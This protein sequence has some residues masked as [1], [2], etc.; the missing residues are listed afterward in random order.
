MKDD[1]ELLR[2]YAHDRSEPAF[3]ELVRRHVNFVYSAA[4]RQ[5]NG[6]AHLAGD[7]TQIVFTDL[8]RKAKSLAGHQVLAGWLFTSTRFAASRL[9]RTEQRRRIREQEAEVMHENEPLETDSAAWERISPVLDEALGQLN[10]VDRDAVLLRYFEGR[11]FSEI[12]R[13]LRLS[14][15]A[16]RM[17]VERALEKLRDQLASRGL[18]STTATLGA[19]LA[20]YGVVGAPTSLGA[21]VTG[22]ALA[23]GGAAAT[24]VFTFMS[25]SKLPAAT[26]AALTLIGGAGY[27]LQA[28]TQAQL[29]EELARLHAAQRSPEAGANTVDKADGALAAELA[30]LRRDDAEFARLAAEAEAL[31]AR[32]GAEKREP[33]SPASIPAVSGPILELREL[34]IRP[35]P[36]IQARPVYPPAMR[37]AGLGGEVVVDFVVDQDGTVRN[38]NVRKSKIVAN[39]TEIRR[40]DLLTRAEPSKIPSTDSSALHAASGQFSLNGVTVSEAMFVAVETSALT[41]VR[42]WEF[43]AGQKSGAKV[44]TRMAIPIVFSPK[45]LPAV[46][47]ATL[48]KLSDEM[49]WF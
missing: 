26:A 8:A 42:Q 36:L 25:M 2:L 44:N 46:T 31:R 6:D 29:R 41:A 17:R 22:A 11:G 38:A 47:P 24:T 10:T 39:E 12:G 43:S 30:D 19:A 49:R 32:F 16:A 18:T 7:V 28:D 34:D 15:N 33:V 23:S 14:E 20:T 9:I 27:F 40:T 1:A 5:V 21:V 13:H 3:S 45:L 4:L 37:Q 48:K 35:S